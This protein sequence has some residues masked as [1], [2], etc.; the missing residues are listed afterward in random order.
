MR[1][2]CEPVPVG[3][4]CLE[5]LVLG[6][7][8]LLRAGEPLIVSVVPSGCFSSSCTERVVTSCQLETEGTA[9]TVTAEFCLRDTSQSGGACTDDCVGGGMAQ[10]ESEAALAEGE[11]T[12]HFGDRTHTFQ[13][14][15]LEPDEICM[16]IAE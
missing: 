13:T 5:P 8:D 6:S 3:R 15:L 1:A 14:G 16:D 12:L 7:G 2:D 9:F 11:H 4:V 10:C